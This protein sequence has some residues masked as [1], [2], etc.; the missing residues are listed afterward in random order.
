[1]ANI[2][3]T[4]SENRVIAEYPSY[5]I[6]FCNSFSEQDKQYFGILTK[7]VKDKDNIVSNSC[8]VFTIYYKLIDHTVH[9]SVGNIFG[10]TCT[11]MSELNVCQEF[12]ESCNG[13]IGAIQTLYITDTTTPDANPYN[14]T[15]RHQ[16]AASPQPSNIS[17]STAHSS[18]SDS[19]IGYKD[20]CTSRSDKN[21]I[22]N[23]SQRRCS[24]SEYR[25]RGVQCF[26]APNEF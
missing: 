7:S 11:K 6:I 21:I 23:L 26:L 9:S 12:P 3:L 18:N 25:V 2:K 10:F 4:N 15:C 19:G 17:T 22:E 14:E 8:H 24:T 20:D 16:E 1:M 5:R 13:L